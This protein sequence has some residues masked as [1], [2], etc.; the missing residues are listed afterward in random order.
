[1]LEKNP[2]MLQQAREMASKY[3]TDKNAL[4]QA[5]PMI[6]QM[7]G[8]DIVSRA[9]QKL[10]AHPMAKMALNGMIGGNID[11]IVKELDQQP[12]TSTYT[13]P[14]AQQTGS[15]KDRLKKYK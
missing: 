2:Q 7:G 14:Q 5:L 12:Q 15:F 3:G 10:N 6:K 13:Q 1:M 8:G 4:K 11:S 9:M